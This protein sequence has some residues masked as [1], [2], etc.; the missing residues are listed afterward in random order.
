[1]IRTWRERM[2]DFDDVEAYTNANIYQMMQKEIDELREALKLRELT[3][4]YVEGF[5]AGKL[6][7]ELELKAARKK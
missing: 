3:D 1:M 5:N 2:E 6:Y 4:K 7:A